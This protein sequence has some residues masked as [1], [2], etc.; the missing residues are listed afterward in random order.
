MRAYPEGFEEE[1][2]GLAEGLRE[3]LHCYWTGFTLEL[4]MAN[5]FWEWIK[6]SAT[7]SI[8]APGL[9]WGI[10]TPTWDGRETRSGHPCLHQGLRDITLITP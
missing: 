6:Q 5:P 7:G 2:A 4:F 3:L 8:G 10:V 1:L 9:S